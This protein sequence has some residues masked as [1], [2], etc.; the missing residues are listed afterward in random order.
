MLTT[1]YAQ[2]FSAFKAGQSTL[3]VILAAA[4]HFGWLSLFF[5]LG[6]LWFAFKKAATR[7]LIQIIVLQFFLVLLLFARVQLID[8]HHYYQ[9]VI[10]IALLQS[11][12]I[13]SIWQGAWPKSSKTFLS[14]LFVGVLAVN[15]VQAFFPRMELKNNPFHLFA[16]AKHYPLTRHDT[17]ELARLIQ[18]LDK[19]VPDTSKL[20][21]AASSLVLNDD[22]V[23]NS[24][25]YLDLP[26]TSI[27]NSIIPANNVDLRDG[28]PRQF[29]AADYIITTDP[30]QFHLR[31]SDQQVVILLAKRLL[32]TKSIGSAYYRLPQNFELDGKIKVIILKKIRPL[33]PEELQ[34]LSNEFLQLYPGRNDLF[35]IQQVAALA[36]GPEDMKKSWLQ[37]FKLKVR[38]L[39]GDMSL[40]DYFRNRLGGSDITGETAY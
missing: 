19:T 39:T 31:P 37:T 6:G 23:R 12:F 30:A 1:N 11:V 15:F 22:V 13:Y 5:A 33:K 9:F 4:W 34:E 24:C 27:C 35:Q 16:G 7:P 32:D 28:F 21:V 20:Y 2:M 8:L 26:Q 25:R 10:V 14:F 40:R 29:L 36:Q 3:Q 38:H 17:P 18:Y